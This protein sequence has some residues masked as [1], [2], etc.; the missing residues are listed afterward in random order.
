MP[1][2][3]LDTFN[4]Q[5]SLECKDFFKKN[6]GSIGTD[7]NM[8]PEDATLENKKLQEWFGIKLKVIPI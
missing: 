5:E 8:G 2:N 7:F 4:I 6:V 1:S 3:N